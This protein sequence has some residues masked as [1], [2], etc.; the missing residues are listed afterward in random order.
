MPAFPILWTDKDDLNHHRRRYRRAELGALIEGAGLRVQRSP[1]STPRL[2]GRRSPRRCA[3][4]RRGAVAPPAAA[5]RLDPLYHIPPALN[6]AVA[7]R[8]G[9]RSARVLRV[10]PFGMSLVCLAEKPGGADGPRGAARPTI[11]DVAGARRSIRCSWS[12]VTGVAYA[13][14]VGNYFWADDF[15]YL[16]LMNDRRPVEFLLT[17]HGGHVQPLRNLVFGFFHWL[18][19]VSAAAPL[20]RRAP[21]HLV[22]AADALR[23]PAARDGQRRLACFGALLWAA[24]PLNEGSLGWF[25]VY[26]HVLVATFLLWVMLR[27]QRAAISTPSPARERAGV[28]AM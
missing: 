25:S 9:A 24:S 18:F 13:H 28:R 27:V 22:N 2:P 12:R 21:T 19:G 5:R 26:G 8:D 10:L 4:P 14:L 3:A 6:R 7:R 23:A 16:Y 1:M 20:R 17:P 15:Y 11:A